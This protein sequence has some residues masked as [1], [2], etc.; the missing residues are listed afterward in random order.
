MRLFSLGV[1]LF[2][3]GSNLYSQQLFYFISFNDKPRFK[4]QLYLPATY[5]SERAIDRRTRNRVPLNIN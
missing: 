1:F 5:I 3:F 4:E 2:L